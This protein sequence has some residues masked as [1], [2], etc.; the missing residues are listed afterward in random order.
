MALDVI[1]AFTHR[2]RRLLETRSVIIAVAAD[3]EGR[4]EYLDAGA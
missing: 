2:R 3:G 4:H 1:A